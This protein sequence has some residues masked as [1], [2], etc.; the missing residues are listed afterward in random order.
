[1]EKILLLIMDK[2]GLGVVEAVRKKTLKGAICIYFLI[3]K[4]IN[5]LNKWMR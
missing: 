4:K 2:G 5:K 3:M 1:M